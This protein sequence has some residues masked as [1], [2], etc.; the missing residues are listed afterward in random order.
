M[1][2]S[3]F[4]YELRERLPL[5]NKLVQRLKVLFIVGIL[6]MAGTAEMLEGE[7]YGNQ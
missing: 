7:R 5:C 4:V 6:L 2:R 3:Q 1:S